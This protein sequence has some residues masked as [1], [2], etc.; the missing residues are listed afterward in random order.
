MEFQKRQANVVVQHF[1]VAV[2][3]S[4]L[5]EFYTANYFAGSCG[6]KHQVGDPLATL[7]AYGYD[8]METRIVTSRKIHHHVEGHFKRFHK[9]VCVENVSN[10]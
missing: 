1:N 4:S 5:L 2:Q 7:S 6:L 8:D 9:P 10:A 3:L